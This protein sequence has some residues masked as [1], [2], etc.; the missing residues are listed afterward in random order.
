MVIENISRACVFL[1]RKFDR[2]PLLRS[3]TNLIVLVQKCVLDLFARIYFFI[4]SQNLNLSNSHYY[5]YIHEKT[6]SECILL[7][8]NPFATAPE[9][10]HANPQQEKRIDPAANPQATPESQDQSREKASI[11]ERLEKGEIDAI[12]DASPSMKDDEDFMLKALKIIPKYKGGSSSKYVVIQEFGPGLV[13]NKNFLLKAMGIFPGT[14]SHLAL[15]LSNDLSND[16]DFMLE[17]TRKF[18]TA[19]LRASDELKRDKKFML[20]AG[21]IIRLDYQGHSFHMNYFQHDPLV[22]RFF[23]DA[24]FWADVDAAIKE[25]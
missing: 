5:K 14:L 17:A 19:L 1:D 9:R 25:A 20:E 3:L 24:A 16:W 23:G 4:F 7:I 13:K 10:S 12:D 2:V 22:Q 21:K 6:Y 11:L 8:F 18:A 15:G